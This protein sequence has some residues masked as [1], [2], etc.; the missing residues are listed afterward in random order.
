MY[1]TSILVLVFV[2]LAS[3]V[4]LY[5]QC[6]GE[7][8]VGSTECDQPLKCFERSRWFSSCQISCPGVDWKC[9]SSGDDSKTDVEDDTVAPNWEQCGGEGWNG[10]TSCG[11]YPCEPRSQWYS[12]CRPDCP[13]GWICS[14][15]I[16]EEI[17][18][19]DLEELEEYDPEL[20][21]EEEETDDFPDP[22]VVDLDALQQRE[23][24]LLGEVDEEE[25]PFAGA[26][27]EEEESTS[28]RR[29][30]NTG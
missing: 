8:Y 22:S 28:R 18:E 27:D 13:T 17:D 23:Q 14:E 6:G 30:R 4:G 19:E 25:D 2:P 26:E 21:E 15:I 7:G 3:S 24:A 16:D 9:V 20:E 10:P 5:Q 11:E 29:R 1:W 12:Q